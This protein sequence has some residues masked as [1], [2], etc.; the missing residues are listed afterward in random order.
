MSTACPEVI[1]SIDYLF[2]T[3]LSTIMSGTAGW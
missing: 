1:L 2:T 3:G